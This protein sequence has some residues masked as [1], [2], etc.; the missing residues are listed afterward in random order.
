MWLVDVD[1][2][3]FRNIHPI[4]ELKLIYSN[5]ILFTVGIDFPLVLTEFFDRIPDFDERVP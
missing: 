1:L 3:I 2:G 5:I 4:V